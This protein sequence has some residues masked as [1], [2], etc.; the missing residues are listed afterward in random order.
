MAI[1][2]DVLT[3]IPKRVKIFYYFLSVDEQ[4]TKGG[5]IMSKVFVIKCNYGTATVTADNPEEA[6]HLLKL[7]EDDA[8]SLSYKASPDDF[9]EVSPQDEKGVKAYYSG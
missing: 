3:K 6:L 9:T 8:E 5:L 1:R 4:T 7:F 2:Q